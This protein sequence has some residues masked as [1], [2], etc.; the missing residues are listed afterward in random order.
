M[1]PDTQYTYRLRAYNTSGFSDYSNEA[2][3]TTPRE[4]SQ[5]PDELPAVP[6]SLRART[7]SYDQIQLEWQYSS[8]LEQGFILERRTETSA[9]VEVARIEA[10]ELQYVD[11]NLTPDTRYY[12]RLAAFNDSGISDFSNEV[13]AVTQKLIK[14]KASNQ[15]TPNGDGI[16]DTWEIETIGEVGQYYVKV[17][18]KAGQV[19]YESTN[20]QG[21]W[22]GS[23][24][25][26][27]LPNGVYYY[28][29]TFADGQKPLKGYISI[30]R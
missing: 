20:Y 13:S 16:N 25:G 27:S 4:V 9:Y 12:Y 15:V 29:L 10:D 17:F 11:I 19:V 21:D 22:N 6:L 7:L 3:V 2:E 14:V 28:T 30:I 5:A 24:Q 1:A 8:D 26:Q 18:S 23:L